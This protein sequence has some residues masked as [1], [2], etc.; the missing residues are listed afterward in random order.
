MCLPRFSLEM[1]SHISHVLSTS[2]GHALLGG[3]GGEGRE[4]F[5]RIAALLADF[6]F[7]S[8]PISPRYGREDW[9]KD[10]AKLLKETG[11]HLKDSVI[12]VTATQLLKKS[13]CWKTSPVSF[14]GKSIQNIKW[15]FA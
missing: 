3:R 1:I 9:R 7:F 11:C 12:Y 8:V 10:L 4:T 5:S 14:L 2:G 6:A 13:F 15:F